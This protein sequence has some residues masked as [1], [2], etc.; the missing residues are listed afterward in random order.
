[1]NAFHRWLP[2][3]LA[4]V[5]VSLFSQPAWLPARTILQ[6]GRTTVWKYLDVGAE[7]DAGWRQLGYDDLHWKSGR[8]PLG[9]GEA[10]IATQV[11]PGPDERHRPITTWIRREFEAPKLKP[12]ERLVVLVSVDDGA[13]LYLNG[14]EVARIN[15]PEGPIGG[16]TFA[17]QTVGN[18]EEGFYHRLPMPTQPLR[19]NETNLLAVEVH[20]ASLVSSDL[21]FDLALK[22][23]PAVEREAEVPPAAL[24]VVRLYHR[25]HYVGPGVRIPDGF[26]DGGRRMLID[27][28][29]RAASAREILA[30]DRARDAEL[31]GDLI[32]AGSADLRALPP[33][34]RAQ[35]IA[36]H[37]D[38][39]TTPPGGPRWVFPTASRLEMEFANK[40]LFIGDWVDQCQAGVCRHRALL[41]KVLADAAG[42]RTA[43]VRG[44]FAPNGPPGFA[45][46]WNE[47][48][49][50]DGRHLLVDVMHNGGEAIFPALSDP[51]VVERY[52]KVDGRPWY[53]RPRK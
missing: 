7:P 5:L 50:D 44:N 1:M 47:L 46:T 11:N 27:T 49:L 13:I 20:Q 45:H 28:A 48:E 38:E 18:D 40:P 30:I 10:R 31:A 16:D 34:E 3:I 35:R 37:L 29:G 15:M 23:S 43:L 8:A 32:F 36:A 51:Q 14:F 9:F 2:R 52:L 39:R 17:R 53:E 26:V 4:A 19:Q 22:V 24:D 42:L 33:L 6:A 12:G 21:F 41:F 25:R